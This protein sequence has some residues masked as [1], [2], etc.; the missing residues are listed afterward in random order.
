MWLELD[1][2]GSLPP[3]KKQ[4]KKNK[5]TNKQTPYKSGIG[6]L[7]NK[8]KTLKTQKLPD[9]PIN[10]VVRIYYYP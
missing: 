6:A 5:Q 4:N 1:R 2:G 10:G 3:P 8:K 9:S 7:R